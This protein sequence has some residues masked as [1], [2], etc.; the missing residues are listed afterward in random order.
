[1]A[2]CSSADPR[3]SSEC[4]THKETAAHAAAA[5]RT[6]GFL[7]AVSASGVV[8]DLDELIGAELLSHPGK[9]CCMALSQPTPYWKNFHR[10]QL[11]KSDEL[12][13]IVQVYKQAT[14]FQGKPYACDRLEQLVRQFSEQ[15]TRDSLF[16][17]GEQTG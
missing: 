7:I 4:Q 17:A 12:K 13:F 9:T 5:A 10:M 6:V 1:M 8:V 11:E 2:S 16:T 14:I 3:A 15:K